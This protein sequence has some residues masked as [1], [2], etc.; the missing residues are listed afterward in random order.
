MDA[1]KQALRVKLGE[2]PEVSMA[3]NGSDGAPPARQVAARLKVLPIVEGLVLI[4]AL[5]LPLLLQDYLTV[6]A[7]RVI[8]LALF[9]LSFVA[10]SA[11]QGVQTGSVRGVVTDATGQIVPQ[12]A[13]R[14][15]S[16]AL[17]GARMTAMDSATRNAGRSARDALAGIGSPI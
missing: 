11:A 6:F 5:V 4:V 7:T 13:I 10:G 16:P 8:I 14:A 12:T 1:V 17:Q 3:E 2:G 9:A 15:E